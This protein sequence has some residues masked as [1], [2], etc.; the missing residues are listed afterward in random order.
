MTYSI[1]LNNGVTVESNS[2][3]EGI[4]FSLDGAVFCYVHQGVMSDFTANQLSLFA[5]RVMETQ[6]DDDSVSTF[7]SIDL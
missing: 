2:M 4:E 6:D 5:D 3:M 7:Q 1:E